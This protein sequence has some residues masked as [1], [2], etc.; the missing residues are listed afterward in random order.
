[1]LARRGGG[2]LGGGRWGCWG[3]GDKVICKM[4]WACCSSSGLN[5]VGLATP[6]DSDRWATLYLGPFSL[7][8]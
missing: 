7:S 4:R 1:M 3:R 5:E 2:G 8:F 6:S